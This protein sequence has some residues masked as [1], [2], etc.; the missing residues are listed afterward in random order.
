MDTLFV[1]LTDALSGVPVAALLAAFAWGVLSIVLSPCHLAGIPL[2]VGYLQGGNVSPRR[3]AGLSMLFALG[4]LVSIALIGLITAAA[5]RLLG[6]A[7]PWGSYVV[8]AVF[9]VFGLHLLGLLP[10]PDR[11][12][13]QPAAARRGALG[14]LA[15]GL[16]FGLALG[17][18]TFGFMAPVLGVTFGVAAS[19]P[20]FAFGLLALFGF[21]HCAVIASAG[22]SCTWVQQWLA[23]QNGSL[24]AK[25]LRRGCGLLVLAAG[26]WLIANT[27]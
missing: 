10:L 14:A 22:I 19:A 16:V 21:G 5:G 18:C 15:F 3:A 27:R 23:W 11:F 8:A 20:L 13:P 2:I 17:P 25:W 12:R 4:I 24:A 6:D 1:S 26:A 7:G 9:I